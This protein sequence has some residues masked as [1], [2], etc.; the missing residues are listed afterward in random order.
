MDVCIKIQGLT[1]TNGSISSNTFTGT[2]GFLQGTARSGTTVCSGNVINATVGVVRPYIAALGTS[3]TAINET[4]NLVSAGTGATC[5]NGGADGL[6][7]DATNSGVSTGSQNLGDLVTN[8]FVDQFWTTL[9]GTSTSSAPYLYSID[10]YLKKN[11]APSGNITVSIYADSAGNPSGAALATSNIVLASALTTSIQ[12][13]HFQFATP[14]ALTASTKYHAVITYSGTIDGLNYIV[15][16]ENSTTTIGSILT[17]TLISGPWTADASHALRTLVSTG[18]YGTT[19]VWRNCSALYDDATVTADHEG[20][21]S[22]PV[23]SCTIAGCI[24][25]N[26]GYGFLA[27]NTLAS[28]FYGNL[29]VCQIGAL[30]GIAAKA[31]VAPKFRNNTVIIGGTATGAGVFITTDGLSVANPVITSAPTVQNNIIKTVSGAA[32][33]SLA[34]STTGSITIDYNDLNMAG[35]VVDK[36][37]GDNFATW[38]GLG[39]DLHSIQSNPQLPN[40]TNPTTAAEIQISATSPCAGAGTTIAG[41]TDIYGNAFRVPQA[42]GATQPPA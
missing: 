41:V 38:Q 1:Y 27:K 3:F 31:A 25:T 8:T 17:A 40:S 33:Y 18:Y 2:K 34:T 29:V 28:D 22:G 5:F 32:P 24:A 14:L 16:D 42:I 12:Q 20:I 37:T 4:C 13:F 11:G 21:N 6:Y 15:L 26:T 7:A 19:S 35:T 9:I 39:Y 10:F 36:I 30:T 23:A